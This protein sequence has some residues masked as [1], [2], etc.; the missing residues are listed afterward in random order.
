MDFKG[1]LSMYH[2]KHSE[3]SNILNAI[4]NVRP[5]SEKGSPFEEERNRRVGREVPK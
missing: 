4:S 5:R 1:E 3:F 2:D